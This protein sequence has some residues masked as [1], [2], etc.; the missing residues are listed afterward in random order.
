VIVDSISANRNISKQSVKSIIDDCILPAKQ[1]K[2][3]KLVDHLVSQDELRDLITKELNGDINI[4][5]NYAEPQREKLDFSNPFALLTQMGKKPT[6][7]PSKDV[8]ALIHAD[9]VIVDGEAED[10]LLG[11]GGNVGSDNIRKAFR[12]ASKDDAVKAIVLRI[13][14]PGGSALASE[15]MWQAV[16]AA[17]EDKPVIVSVGSMAASGG[18]YLASA[19]DYIIADPSAIVGSI[20]VVGGKFVLTG[21]LRQAR[22]RHRDL[23]PRQELGLFSMNTEWTDRQ[24]RMVQN[25]MKQ[26]YEQFTERVMTN[27]KGKI[28]DID[29]VARGRIFV[30]KQAKELGMVDEIGGLSEAIKYAAAEVDFKEYDVRTIPASKSDHR[31]ADGARRQPATRSPH[32]LPPEDRAERRQPAEDHARVDAQAVPATASDDPAPRQALRS[33]WSART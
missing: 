25:W 6:T 11:G 15:V 8:I 18:Y 17:A 5:A 22:R 27:R 21:P 7:N 10:G 30:A 9:G 3:R 33:C 1:A 20:G 13:D 32:A 31:H 12:I 14:S 16:H 28:K 2:D 4:L 26:T 24:R 23:Q 19:G 29:Q